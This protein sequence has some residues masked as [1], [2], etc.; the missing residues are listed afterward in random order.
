MALTIG[1]GIKLSGQINIAINPPPSSGP[2]FSYLMG[3]SVS[4]N[5]QGFDLSYG[6]FTGQLSSVNG[7]NYIFD[8]SADYANGSYG[9]IGFYYNDHGPDP[10]TTYPPGNTFVNHGPLS[11]LSF[12]GLPSDDAPG[13]GQYI[14]S[15][16]VNGYVLSAESSY[17]I[18]SVVRVND[19]GPPDNP[20]TSTGGIVGGNQMGFGFIS[21]IPGEIPSN[22]PF[23]YASNNL[24][25]GPNDVLD[26][27]TQF[28]TN[29]WYAVAV[30]YDA[31][32]QTM[33]LY[34][35]GI[36]TATQ[37]GLAPFPNP[38]PLYWGTWQGLNWL[39]GD[40]AVMTVWDRALR[41]EEI[42]SYT[43]T[44]G[45]PYGV[46]SAR[47]DNDMPLQ[48]Y[49][50]LYSEPGTYTFTVPAGVTSISMV[51]VGAGGGGGVGGYAPPGGDTYVFSQWNNYTT[52]ITATGTASAVEYITFDCTTGT[53]TALLGNVASGW[54]VTGSQLNTAYPNVAIIQGNVYGIVT[55]VDSSNISNVV[56][57][58]N[59][60][61]DFTS[62]DDFYFLG[63]GIL[64]VQGGPEADGQ[65]DN[66][67]SG[68][69]PR[70]QV[71]IG[72]GG[73][74]GVEDYFDSDAVGGA[75]AG[76]YGTSA[77]IVSFDPNQTYLYNG[78]GD[79]NLG[80][81]QTA[82]VLSNNNLTATAVG[83][84]NFGYTATGTYAIE[85]TDKVMFSITQDLWAG[86][87]AM[88]IGL[89]NYNA[90]IQNYVGG[91]TNSI[92][93]FDDGIVFYNNSEVVTGLPTFPDNGQII[94]IA[95][96]RNN[97]SMWIRI[98]GGYWNGNVSENPATNTGGIEIMQGTT[99]DPNLYLMLNVGYDTDH[100]S[101]SINT[102]NAYSI[103]S[104]YTFIA[105]SANAG[106]T[107][108][109]GAKYDLPTNKAGQGAGGSGGGGGGI[110]YNTGTGGGGTGLY[111]VGS[112][113]ARGG[114]VNYNNYDSGDNTFMA[115]GAGGGSA[116]GNSGTN[117]GIA[118]AW[119][120]G[121]G[122]WPGGAG[123]S[124]TDYYG[125]GNGG[126]LA[127]LNNVS[128]TPNTYYTV[129]VG[130]G[131]YGVGNDNFNSAGV[132][133]GGGVRIVWPGNTRTFPS[134]NV[135]L[136]SAG[137][138]SITIGTTDFTERS[139][140]NNMNTIFSGGHVT[141]LTGTAGS[142]II[143]S[144]ATLYGLTNNTLAQ[145]ITAMFRQAGMTT[146]SKLNYQYA[147]PNINH[148]N[149]YIFNVIWADSSTGKVRMS[150]DASGGLLT[151]CVIDTTSSD[152]EIASPLD[153]GNPN[154]V[155][156]G[157][158][159]F[160]ATF[161]PVTPLIESNG[162]AWC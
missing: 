147:T 124:G 103:P 59:K 141:G 104:G 56:I 30:T 7:T 98:D 17:T 18:F 133:A 134:T 81:P 93:Y 12:N 105:G 143:D 145:N 6:N 10:L 92:G 2:I 127:Y 111:G 148:F 3:N 32:S 115:A 5:G 83:N 14:D 162:D 119:A 9:N 118:S 146:V 75:G 21:P 149:A 36:N 112:A 67:F 44:Y 161:T 71:L 137:P 24:L 114:W 25:G 49:S 66:G 79:N 123:G 40:L 53:A 158:F 26:F 126:A 64:G 62:S 27:Y 74:G 131:G 47:Q 106:S 154:P 144:Y 86:T 80:I 136:D 139:N 117:G 113:G 68:P 138:S 97:N 16:I 72:T 70:A 48:T 43:T 54:L 156:A 152:W 142:N 51:G 102:S 157:T 110:C 153:S 130:Q 42:S 85:P 31:G 61:I 60:T 45:A 22:Y 1:G 95:V 128:V 33:K 19:F 101:M 121:A 82:V 11:Y 29:T 129:I 88:A 109:D 140:N 116:L 90:N 96:D 94:D 99:E 84:T 125:A 39:N 78:N 20:Y 35:N 28:Q 58:I 63:Q 73:R 65:Y 77:T 100:G 37:T 46:T 151:L 55:N 41:A 52:P 69:G 108:G 155:K 135:G 76:G 122:G 34:V 15:N 120:G 4:F 89:G 8:T 13:T 132:G 23:L 57:T 160:P 91:D 38:E 87:D 50:Q 107:G 159:N 150:W